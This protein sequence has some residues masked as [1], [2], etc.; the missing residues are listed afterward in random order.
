MLDKFCW[1]SEGHVT[2]AETSI[3]IKEFNSTAWLFWKIGKLNSVF[4]NCIF[5]WGHTLKTDFWCVLCV[6]WEA[7]DSELILLSHW[8]VV[9]DCPAHWHRRS[10]P[11]MVNGPSV[12]LSQSRALMRSV[13]HL[14]RK[15]LQLIA[16]SGIWM[17][18]KL[19]NAAAVITLHASHLQ[20]QLM[21]TLEWNPLSLWRSLNCKVHPVQ[22]GWTAVSWEECIKTIIILILINSV[23]F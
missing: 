4:S 17:V 13:L 12:H 22:P 8:L 10:L 14:H 6:A 20:M 16:I 21:C 23:S 11:V 9:A 7:A 19:H 3:Q 1:D 2:T 18:A 15:R 5:Y